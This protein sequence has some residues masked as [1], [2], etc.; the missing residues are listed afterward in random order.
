MPEVTGTLPYNLDNL[1]GGAARVV[2]S[3]DS[4]PMPAVPV[5]LKDIID[6]EKPYLPQTVWVDIGST[7]DSTEYQRDFEVE[8]WD[9]QQVTGSVFEE[10]TE[11][12]R[13][14]KVALAEFKPEHLLI[15]EEAPAIDSIAAAAGA[16]AQ[17]AVKFGS[18]S[19]LTN[20]RVAFIAQR[21]P[22]S[23]EVEETDSSTRGRFVALVLYSATIAPEASSAEVEKGNLTQLPVTFKAFPEGGEDQGQEFGTWLL[24]DAGTIT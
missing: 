8:G 16:V 3:D 4:A 14:L 5:N 6:C 22:K 2:I 11:T 23:G 21:N 24:E 9:I 10:V 20:R 17:K 15:V 1:L 13:T 7:A 12:E 19:Q 18:F